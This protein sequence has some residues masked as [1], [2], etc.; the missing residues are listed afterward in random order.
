MYGL[1]I[2]KFVFNLDQCLRKLII[3]EEIYRNIDNSLFTFKEQRKEFGLSGLE[4]AFYKVF[5]YFAFYVNSD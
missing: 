5:F 1:K 3:K 2:V 4:A